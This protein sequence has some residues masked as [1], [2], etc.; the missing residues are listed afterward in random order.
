[1]LGKHRQETVAKDL[2]QHPSIQVNPLEAQSRPGPEAIPVHRVFAQT[3]VLINQL[4]DLP[5]P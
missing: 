1:M 2:R 5:K 3:I 4:T